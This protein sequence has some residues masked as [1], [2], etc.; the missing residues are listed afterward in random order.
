MVA[1]TADQYVIDYMLVPSVASRCVSHELHL[2]KPS[3]G[4]ED[5][6]LG[7]HFLIRALEEQ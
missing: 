4:A 2:C 7:C 5:Q 6:R 3:V 1:Q